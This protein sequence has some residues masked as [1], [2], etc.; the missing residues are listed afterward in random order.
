MT[1]N[2]TEFKSQVFNRGIA[3]TNKFVATITRS[4]TSGDGRNFENVSRFLCDTASIPGLGFQTADVRQMGYGNIDKRPYLTTFEDLSTTFIVDNKGEVYKYFHNWGR[5]IV[6]FN[7]VK[8]GSSDGNLYSFPDEYYAV[9]EIIQ[10]DDAGNK[11]LTVKLNKAYPMQIGAI[12]LSW[13]DSGTIA[14]L[15]VTFAFNSW[16][17]DYSNK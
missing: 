3:K 17:S 2:V 4:N 12:A 8:N 10:Y 9:I 13:A 11:L 5:D 15:P 7:E 6:D 1:F 16:E 14:K